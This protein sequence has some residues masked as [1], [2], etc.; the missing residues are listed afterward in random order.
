MQQKFSGENTECDGMVW[1]LFRY[2][3]QNI[4]LEY[5]LKPFIPDYI[6]AVG[7]IDAF[8]KVSKWLGLT[9]VGLLCYHCR[10]TP[11][12]IELDHSL[13]PFIPDLIPAVGDIDA[14]LKVSLSGF[15]VEPGKQWR[16]LNHLWL[17]IYCLSECLPTYSY[18]FHR[19]F[20]VSLLQHL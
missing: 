20:M 18:L 14:F 11:Q 4:E 2:T 3:P 1:F 16:W 19:Y 17:Y 7:D 5:K 12:T 6:P 10:Y 15:F 8:I 9:S 13:L